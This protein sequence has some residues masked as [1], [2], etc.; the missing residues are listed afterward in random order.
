MGHQIEL[1]LD[2][3]GCRWTAD[4]GVL[5]HNQFGQ[6]LF[7]FMDAAQQELT[8]NQEIN[9]SWRPYIL[10]HEIL[11]ALTF[12]GHLQFLRIKGELRDDEAKVDALASLLA[13]V[14]T[15]NNLFNEGLLNPKAELS[16]V[17]GSSSSNTEPAL[18]A[19][20]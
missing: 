4:V 13:E 19:G 7:G 18:E 10:L 5:A 16:I 17:K 2:I 8:I 6:V 1:D 20:L 9:P 11:H 14:L 15:R 3:L 12:M